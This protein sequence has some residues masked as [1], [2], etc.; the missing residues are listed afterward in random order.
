MKIIDLTHPL[1]PDMPVYPG[2]EHPVFAAAG[3]I[4]THGFAEKKITFHSHNGT[5]IDAPAH[6]IEGGKTLDQLP[7]DH[8]FG[9]ALVI[10]AVDRSHK[11][12]GI[13]TLKPYAENIRT[14]DFLLL[15]TGWSRHWG[16]GQ[17]FS[18]YPVLSED[19]A[20]W[21]VNFQLKGLGSDTISADSADAE[22]FRNHKTL[23]GKGMIIIENLTNLEDLSQDPV[24]F[25]C[26][27]LKIVD[28]DGS[29]VRAVGMM[30]QGVGL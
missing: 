11:M 24:G 10:H 15:H 21:L 9:K 13:E 26:L 12:I 8:F 23:L 7:V 28:A 16:S 1:S 19:A 22:E 4:E 5:H 18:D 17:Y 2:T 25:S 30:G 20:K 29:P 14:V 6:M 3:A 27:P